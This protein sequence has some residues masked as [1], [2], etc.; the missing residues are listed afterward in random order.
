[1]KGNRILLK[2]SVC[3]LPGYWITMGIIAAYFVILIGVWLGIKFLSIRVTQ[4]I[5]QST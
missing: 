2:I 4:P 1:L 3:T 5:T